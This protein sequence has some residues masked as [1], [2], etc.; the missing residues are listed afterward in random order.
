MDKRKLGK[1]WQETRDSARKRAVNC[2]TRNIKR[3]IRKRALERWEAK[4]GN[5][6]VA[7]YLRDRET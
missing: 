5:C 2:V 3:I 1:L 7:L 6:E 4:L